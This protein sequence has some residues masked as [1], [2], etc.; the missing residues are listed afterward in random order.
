MKKINRFIKYN[1]LFYPFIA[2]VYWI[3]LR[4]QHI[5]WGATST[6][7]NRRFPIEEFISPDRIVSTRVIIMY[8]TRFNGLHTSLCYFNKKM[9]MIGY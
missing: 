2:L 9:K 5:N 3:F 4:P 1:I 8:V 7:I 6:E